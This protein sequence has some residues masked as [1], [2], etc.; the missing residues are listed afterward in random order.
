[1][2]V[3]KLDTAAYTQELDHTCKIIEFQGNIQCPLNERILERVRASTERDSK[4]DTTVHS[5][6]I[7][8]K[9]DLRRR[10]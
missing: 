2:E 9:N 3:T 4:H 6:C 7:T 10:T 5:V 8:Q 1:M